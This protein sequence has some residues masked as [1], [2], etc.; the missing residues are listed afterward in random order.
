MRYWKRNRNL[1]QRNRKIDSSQSR[2]KSVKNSLKQ[3]LSYLEKEIQP[4]TPT[5]KHAEK[6]HP[7]INDLDTDIEGEIIAIFNNPE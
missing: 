5:E 4:T 2:P 7:D 1:P 3:A 6:D